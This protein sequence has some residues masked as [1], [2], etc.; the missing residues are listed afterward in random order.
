M[1]DVGQ[2]VDDDVIDNFGF[3]VNKAPVERQGALAG[4]TTPAGFLLSE[5]DGFERYVHL[6]AYDGDLVVEIV[7][8]LLA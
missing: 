2:F 4:A 7:A 3:K 1:S 5:S 6:L 8:G